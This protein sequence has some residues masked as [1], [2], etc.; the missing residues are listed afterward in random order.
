MV[1]LSQ[2]ILVILFFR[3]TAKV[4]KEIRKYDYN[5]KLGDM[6]DKAVMVSFSVQRG[7]KMYVHFNRGYLLTLSELNRNAMYGV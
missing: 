7:P 5:D 6:S 2:F 3:N 1:L 4:L